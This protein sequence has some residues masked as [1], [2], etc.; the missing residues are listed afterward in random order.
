MNKQAFLAKHTTVTA[1]DV[2]ALLGAELAP[3]VAAAVNATKE[4]AAATIKAF[5]VE[6]EK[7]AGVTFVR[8]QT[9]GELAKQ[10]GDL[11][12]SI[13]KLEADVAAG[14][15]DRAKL[16]G[17]LNAAKGKLTE[18]EAEKADRVRV[19]AVKAELAKLTKEAKFGAKIVKIA[20]E[21]EDAP[22][23]ARTF[24][25]ESAKKF[26]EAKLAEYADLVAESDDDDGTSRRRS[27]DQLGRVGEE[28]DPDADLPFGD[29][30][31][32]GESA[33]KRTGKPVLAL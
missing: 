3:K 8:E 25:V 12:A 4:A 7:V 21:G 29:T 1:E 13:K 27:G 2:D 6:A 17:E 5:L 30:K 16:E 26:V 19:E 20:T 18:A 28:D 15:A 11:N 32:T 31:P 10:I 24:T 22:I 23:K 14:T 33:G 9:D